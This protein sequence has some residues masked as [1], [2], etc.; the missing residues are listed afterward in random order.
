M[1]RTFYILMNNISTIFELLIS[2][3]KIIEVNDIVKGKITIQCVYKFLW[4]YVYNLKMLNK[5][6]C[7]D[8]ITILFLCTQFFFSNQMSQLIY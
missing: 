7:N 5:L 4:N 3:F 8:M 2:F 6:T 1:L